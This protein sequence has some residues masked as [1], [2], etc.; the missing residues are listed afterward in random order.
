MV[1]IN[2]ID[3]V[4][5]SFNLKEYVKH[6]AT[7][8]IEFDET[9]LIPT[10]SIFARHGIVFMCI[11]YLKRYNDMYLDKVYGKCTCGE[12]NPCRA[13]AIKEDENQIYKKRLIKELNELT[14]L[15]YVPYINFVKKEVI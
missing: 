9:G 14:V 2:N 10:T 4:L 8:E 1:S 12:C 13:R 15:D 11:D 3:K 7:L 5:N 6:R